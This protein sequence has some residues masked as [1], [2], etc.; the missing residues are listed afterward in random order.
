MN[1]DNYKYIYFD[2]TINF[3]CVNMHKIEEKYNNYVLFFYSLTI[4]H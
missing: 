4:K 2:N 3:I 1:I